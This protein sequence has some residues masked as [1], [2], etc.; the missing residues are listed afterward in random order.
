MNE[1]IKRE[2]DFLVDT[3]QSMSAAELENFQVNLRQS[4]IGIP[5]NQ[6]QRNAFDRF[7]SLVAA[8]ATQQE[9]DATNEGRV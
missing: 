4:M 9:A 5:Y 1:D 3:L 6:K 7:R 8:I 2:T